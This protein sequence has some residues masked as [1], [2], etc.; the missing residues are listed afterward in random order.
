MTIVTATLLITVG[1]YTWKNRTLPVP[2]SS[3]PQKLSLSSLLRF[4]KP[5]PNGSILYYL[6]STLYSS[7]HSTILFLS[8]PK[9]LLLRLRFRISKSTLSITEEDKKRLHLEHGSQDKHEYLQEENL[10][11]R[12]KLFLLLTIFSSLF[13]FQ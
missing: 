8:H 13:I 4:P 2:E 12:F 10:P 1:C 11:Q 9:T 3:F 6:L 5:K 7:L